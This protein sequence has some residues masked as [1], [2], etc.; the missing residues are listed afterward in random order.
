MVKRKRR[1]PS[2]NPK[3]RDFPRCVVPAG[4]SEKGRTKR[5][6][7]QEGHV[8]LKRLFFAVSLLLIGYFL[9]FFSFFLTL[10]RMNVYLLARVLT[11]LQNVRYKLHQP[12]SGLEASTSVSSVLSN[13]LFH[14]FAFLF[15]SVSLLLLLSLS[16]S[17]HALIP[18]AF[19][20]AFYQIPRLQS[21]ATIGWFTMLLRFSRCTYNSD[22]VIKQLQ[23]CSSL[24]S[25]Q[26]ILEFSGFY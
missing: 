11:Q 3:H 23:K 26:S 21:L 18:L 10:R 15:P 9:L 25:L 2:K 4:T 20:L 19:P 7:L 5:S 17:S 22:S 12:C 13:S 1:K 6:K 14:L 16:L 8:S 24:S